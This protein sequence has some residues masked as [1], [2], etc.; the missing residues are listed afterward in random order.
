MRLRAR[1]INFTKEESID[2]WARWRAG[3]SAADIA[4]SFKR[5]TPSV[6]SHVLGRGGFPPPKRIRRA[7]TL[8]VLEREEVSRGLSRGE[9]LHS[10][11][12]QL[13]RPTST[14]SRE[15]SRNGGRDTYRASKADEA[16][17]ARA[18][19]P[20][21]CK[22]AQHGRLRREVARRLGM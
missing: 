17:G 18:L 22:L 10:I 2:I 7:G 11:A 21:Q 19:R 15:V 4:R 3:E 5:S 16:A 8:T 1:R 9:S 13:G 20:K 6:Y 12:R 14:I